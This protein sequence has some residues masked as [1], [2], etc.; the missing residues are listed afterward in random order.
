MKTFFIFKNTVQAGLCFV[1]GFGKQG[2]RTY[3][4]LQPTLF[5]AICTTCALCKTYYTSL[6]KLEL[7]N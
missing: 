2:T 5:R 1:F 6:H 7:I 3:L 4:R